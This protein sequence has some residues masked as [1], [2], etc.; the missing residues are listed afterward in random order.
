MSELDKD[1]LLRQWGLASRGGFV[2]LIVQ[3][4]VW[5]SESG[6]DACCI[7]EEVVREIE[8][9]VLDLG[10]FNNDLFKIVRWHYV[11]GIYKKDIEL[12][13]NIKRSTLDQYFSEANGWVNSRVYKFSQ[14]A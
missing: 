9:A 1:Y 14:V 6:G 7:S 3:T 13:L 10:R 4:G 8:S 2:G 5:R 11:F 12:R